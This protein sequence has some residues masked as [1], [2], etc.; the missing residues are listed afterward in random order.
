MYFPL[1]ILFFTL[2]FPFSICCVIESSGPVS[3]THLDVYKRQNWCDWTYRTQRY[4]TYWTYWGQW[5]NWCDWTYCCLLYTSLFSLSSNIIISFLLLFDNGI[6]VMI[7]SLITCNL[8]LAT[9]KPVSYTHLIL[10]LL[11]LHFLWLL[12]FVLGYKI[13]RQSQYHFYDI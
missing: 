7:L 2:S 10:L 6:E 3:Y 8:F 13:E 4:W 1:F 12:S 9:P 11:V 5:C